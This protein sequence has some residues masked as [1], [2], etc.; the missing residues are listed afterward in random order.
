MDPTDI[1]SS[2]Q[3]SKNTQRGSRSV[4]KMVDIGGKITSNQSASKKDADNLITINSSQ[5]NAVKPQKAKNTETLD[6]TLPKDAE[7]TLASTSDNTKLEA[8]SGDVSLIEHSHP[9]AAETIE[10]SIANAKVSLVKKPQE[11]EL[12]T[13]KK[14]GTKFASLLKVVYQLEKPKVQELTSR[15]EK[16]LMSSFRYSPLHYKE[17]FRHLCLLAKVNFHQ[18]ESNDSYHPLGKGYFL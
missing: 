14:Y 15:I 1:L 6:T 9:P 2:L 18:F 17:I 8:S 7:S 12:S 10:N 3:F 11:V 16:K 13:R 5:K 4:S